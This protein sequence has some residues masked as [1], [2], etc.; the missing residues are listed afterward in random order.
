MKQKTDGRK[1]A[2]DS[3]ALRVSKSRS[4]VD[5]KIQTRGRVWFRKGGGYP[6]AR[7][8][9]ELSERYGAHANQICQW[10]RQF[11]EQTASVFEHRAE[12]GGTEREEELLTEVGEFIVGHEFSAWASDAA[13]AAP[14]HDLR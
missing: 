7:D 9:P 14:N 11:V 5:P 1:G 4:E 8:H 10:K 2:C 12:T 13:E 6:P 3:H